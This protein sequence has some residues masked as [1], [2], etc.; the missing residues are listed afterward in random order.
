MHKRPIRK[1][2]PLRANPNC[3]ELIRADA[4]TNSI[5]SEEVIKLKYVVIFMIVFLS[6]IRLWITRP[7]HRELRQLRYLRYRPDCYRLERLLCRAGISP[8]KT[9]AL[10]RRTVVRWIVTP[11]PQFTRITQINDPDQR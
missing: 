6:F 11:H 9:N 8:L 10:S 2:E 5:N 4:K 3:G 1:L 7:F